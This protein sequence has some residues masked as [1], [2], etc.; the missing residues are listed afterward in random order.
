MGVTFYPRPGVVRPP[1]ALEGRSLPRGHVSTDIAF[2]REY[3]VRAS[4]LSAAM[5]EA[6]RQ[7]IS[8]LEA[9]LAGGSVTDTL[10]YRSLAH[11]IDAP[12]RTAPAP[13]DPATDALRALRDGR[14]RLADGT[15][16]LAP[17][18]AALQLLVD[19]ARSPDLVPR[20]IAITT[21]A[22]LESLVLKRAGAGLARRASLALPTLQPALSARGALDA[23]A[24]VVAFGI[25]ATATALFFT[26]PGILA[27]LA[28]TLF[29]AAVGFRS[30]ACT[31]GQTGRRTASAALPVPDA[32]L[33]RYSVLVPLL[34]EAGMVRDLVRHLGALDYPAG[35]LEILLL[36]EADDTATRAALDFEP[37]PHRMRVVVVPPGEPRT[38]PRALNV[39]LALA[40]GSLV[41]VYDAEDRP[42]PD[43]LRA[44]AAR[45]ASASPRLACLQ[46]RLAVLPETRLLARG[47]MEHP[48]Q[49]EAA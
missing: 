29:L 22:H 2:L 42:E 18:G 49:A 7:G 6:S 32:A 20:S 5:G 1:A 38:K 27:A 35:K 24:I 11:L 23:K 46:G 21:P 3:G 25:L 13:L 40:S 17:T 26:M 45:Y 16:L 44:A 48:P 30:W 8:A 36:V 12:F 9:L 19:S 34:R 41:T 43:Q 33:P 31:V 39:G 37:R 47:I 15:W 10:V 28:G 4:V 14:V